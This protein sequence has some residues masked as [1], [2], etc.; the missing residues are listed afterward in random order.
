MPSRPSPLL[1]DDE[2]QAPRALV[3]HALTLV[4]RIHRGDP[5]TARAAD[6]ELAR[7]RQVSAVNAEAAATAQRIWNATAA[8]GLREELPKPLAAREER[9]ARRR[10]LG[11]LGV[12]AMAALAAGGGR[13]YWQ[14][15]VHEAALRTGHAQLLS[16]TLPDG[17]ILDLAANTTADI[18]LYR[19]R[20]FVRLAGGEVRFDVA[21]DPDRPFTVET[22]WGRVQVLGTVFTVSSRDSRMRVAVAEGRVAVWASSTAGSAAA[23]AGTGELPPLMLKAG[24]AVE[25]D[26]GGLGGRIAID[27]SE[28]A[29]W[30]QGWLVFRNTPL[31]E[32]VRRWNDYL[33]HP[34]RL[35]ADPAMNGMRL[36]GR[37]RLREPQAFLDSLRDMLPVRVVAAA[38]GAIEIA[39]RR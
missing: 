16:R 14:R 30:K 7:W 27:E 3:A 23:Q 8:E 24:E 39:P 11:L 29:D 15:P 21:R 12:S 1:S 33:R 17:S 18:A 26:A 19:D 20:R 35:S 2:R 38:D 25:A 28:V 37:Y 32:A 31:P 6:R 10:V 5:D 4:G 9:V 13:W 36:S 34:M 22:D